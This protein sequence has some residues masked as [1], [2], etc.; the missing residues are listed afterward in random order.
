MP[1]GIRMTDMARGI[2]VNGFAVGIFVLSTTL[3]RWFEFGG[4]DDPPWPLR[5]IAILVVG[6]WLV[7]GVLALAAAVRL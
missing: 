7:T 1:M 5:H 4:P 2:L 3:F 6:V